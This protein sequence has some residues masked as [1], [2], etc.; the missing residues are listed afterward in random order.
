M[1]T[2]YKLFE[3]CKTNPINFQV[4][5]AMEQKFD[6]IKIY[7]VFFLFKKHELVLNIYIYLC[8]STQTLIFLPFQ[9]NLQ[10]ATL[11]DKIK[12][13]YI[14]IYIYIYV[15]FGTFRQPTETYKAK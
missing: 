5:G 9:L 10:T 4:Y 11:Q 3:T 12:Y 13:I 6:K 2:T 15:R 7:L 8:E 14:Y 1:E